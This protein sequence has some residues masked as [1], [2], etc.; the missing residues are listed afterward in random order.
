MMPQESDITTFQFLEEIQQAFLRSK[1]SSN[2]EGDSF[3]TRR[4]VNFF[5]NTAALQ[6]LKAEDSVQLN[7]SASPIVTLSLQSVAKDGEH[8][9]FAIK[10]GANADSKPHKMLLLIHDYEHLKHES[11]NIVKLLGSSIESALKASEASSEAA[12]SPA[13]AEAADD[14]TRERPTRRSRLRTR[15]DSEA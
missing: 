9:T 14:S 10:I 2:A 11:A 7:G 3:D 13:S 15:E 1:G 8:P 12:A 4:M 5:D 6:I